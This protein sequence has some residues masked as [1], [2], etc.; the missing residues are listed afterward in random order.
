MKKMVIALGGILAIM[1]VFVGCTSKKDM[2]FTGSGLD[3]I[4]IKELVV[5]NDVT[6]KTS[7]ITDADAISKFEDELNNIKITDAKEEGEHSG[8]NVPGKNKYYIEFLGDNNQ[9]VGDLIISKAG[10]IQINNFE[11]KYIKEV[12]N[13]E[14]SKALE[15]IIETNINP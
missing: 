2:M 12:Q 14:A 3:K 7:N 4:H 6:K 5:T 11:T 15:E 13:E 10:D 8:C 9:V 1:L